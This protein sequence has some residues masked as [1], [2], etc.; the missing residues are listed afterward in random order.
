LSTHHS[1]AALVIEF[2]KVAFKIIGQTGNGSPK[3]QNQRIK[4][5]ESIPMN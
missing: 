4:A 5:N 2:E 1:G 3:L